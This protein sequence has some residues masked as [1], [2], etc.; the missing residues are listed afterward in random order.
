MDN[1]MNMDDKVW[2]VTLRGIVEKNIDELLSDKS[3][4]TYR[5]F[6]EMMQPVVKSSDDALFGYIYGLAYGNIEVLFSML[7][8]LPTD[9][10]MDE[11]M[12]TFRKRAFDIKS[13]IY[14]TKT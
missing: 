4:S 9:E 1:T 7:K 2:L 10:E 11:V 6:L 14:Q 8:R 13:R 3:L 5:N 12:N